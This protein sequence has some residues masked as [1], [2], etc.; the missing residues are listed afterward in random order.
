MMKKT[1]WGGLRNF[2]AGN[3]IDVAEVNQLHWLEES[4]Q[5]LENVD[6][7]HLVLASGKPVLQKNCIC[8]SRKKQLTTTTGSFPESERI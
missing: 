2:F 3:I 1:V 8:I 6:Q 7:T 5:W 4:R